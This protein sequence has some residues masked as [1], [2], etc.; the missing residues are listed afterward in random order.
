MNGNLFEPTWLLFFIN[1][2]LFIEMLWLF[3]GLFPLS[4]YIFLQI[5]CGGSHKV[6]NLN[7]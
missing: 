7:K 4:L 5:W 2:W 1:D 3:H 6:L